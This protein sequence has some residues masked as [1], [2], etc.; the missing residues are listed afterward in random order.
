MNA[1][2]RKTKRRT[3]GYVTY[4]EN[5]ADEL[6][7]EAAGHLEDALME[8]S[9][10]SNDIQNRETVVAEVERK[11]EILETARDAMKGIFWMTDARG[12]R[13]RVSIPD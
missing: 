10:P 9:D 7:D 4:R 12:E 6:I 8:A 2:N 5:W 11:I 13:V 1:R 3:N